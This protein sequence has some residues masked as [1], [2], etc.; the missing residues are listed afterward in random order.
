MKPFLFLVG[1]LPV[2]FLSG[3]DN[4]ARG[5]REGTQ[6][7]FGYETERGYVEVGIRSPAWLAKKTM[8]TIV[9]R[10]KDDI[11]Q[12]DTVYDKSDLVWWWMEKAEE[13]NPMP[14]LKAK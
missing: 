2:L 12:Y 7:A 8:R 14:G 1:L 4:P 10:T 5:I 13:Q 3:C 9:I 11:A 6:V